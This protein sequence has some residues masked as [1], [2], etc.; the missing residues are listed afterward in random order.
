M[1]NNTKVDERVKFSLVQPLVSV[2]G[3][4]GSSVLT[5]TYNKY[6]LGSTTAFNIGQMGEWQARSS[7][8]DEFKITSVTLK[9]KP[10]YTEMTYNQQYS[11]LS[12]ISTVDCYTAI[13]RDGFNAFSASLNIPSLLA[14]YDSFQRKSMFKPWSRT[15]KSSLWMNTSRALYAPS[16]APQHLINAGYIQELMVYV[17]NIPNITKD[18]AWGQ[19]T[20]EYHVCFRGKKPVSLSYDALSGSTIVTPISSF[21]NATDILEP[22]NL[23]DAPLAQANLVVDEGVIKVQLTGPN[24]TG[25]VVFA[26]KQNLDFCT[27]TGP[28]GPTGPTGEAPPLV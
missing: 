14:Q 23:A 24:A 25:T 9:Y 10:Y 26:E 17:A 20:I 1:K 12:A 3:P 8:Y 15:L 2:N 4:A 19:I 7:L 21:A 5:Y 18:Q 13:D 6:G 27:C 11:P 22:T 16:S 28:P